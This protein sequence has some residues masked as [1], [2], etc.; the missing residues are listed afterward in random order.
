MEAAQ[1]K[2]LMTQLSLWCALI[3]FSH[4]IFAL[5]FA[6]GMAVIAARYAPAATPVRFS[7]LAWILVALVSARTAAMAFNRVVDKEFDRQN[8]R[9]KERPLVSG[10]ISVRS[11]LVL[12]MLSCLMFFLSAAAL[13]K[14]CI[15]LAPFVLGVLLFYSYTKRFTHY[16]HLVLGL[17][18]ALAPGGVWYALTTEFAVLPIYL[19]AAVMLW[20]AGFDILYACQDL[21]FD[22]QQILFSLPVHLGIS[23]AL[24]AAR[25]CH[26]ASVILLF[27]F[28]LMA[29][30]GALY[31]CGIAVF[32][33]LLISEHR[34]VSPHDLSRLEAAFFTRNGMA[35]MVFFAAVALD[36]L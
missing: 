34:L 22:R 14:H 20:V 28:G 27:I 8:P 26:L 3:K 33:L 29:E 23:G 35:S 2:S 13:G 21:D 36:A 19:M 4:T 9:T 6:L 17:C 30:L 11:V 32:G 5:P 18:L 15:V 12:L 1:R 25:F 24:M 10:I 7:Q 31:Y 16:S